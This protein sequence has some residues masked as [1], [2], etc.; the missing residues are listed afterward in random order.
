MT[1]GMTQERLNH[2]QGATTLPLFIDATD[3]ELAWLIENSREMYLE[4]GE[5]FFR[6]GEP[7]RQ[8]YVVLEGELQVFRH[9]DGEMSRVGHDATGCDRRRALSAERRHCPGVGAGH[10]A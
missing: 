5:Y 8:F 7:A 4:Q 10:H 6:E 9:L 2:M 3:D 1:R